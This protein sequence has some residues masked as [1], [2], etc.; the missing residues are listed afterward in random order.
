M[1]D[2]RR[3][4]DKKTRPDS[5]LSSQGSRSGSE[6][7]TRVNYKKT[8]S[9]LENRTR[10]DYDQRSGSDRRSKSDHNQTRAETKRIARG[11]YEHTRSGSRT[12]S[13]S[14]SKTRLD[15][16]KRDVYQTLPG[17]T[18]KQDFNKRSKSKSMKSTYSKENLRLAKF[19]Q[20]ELLYN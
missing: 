7:R 6:S 1:S 2:T 9:E 4:L 11:D 8:R 13:G 3:Y 19:V 15:S 17:S 20:K 18:E 16:R 10:S 12:R 5:R 14:E